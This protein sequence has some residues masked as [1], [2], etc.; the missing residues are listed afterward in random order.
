MLDALTYSL[1]DQFLGE[2][3]I[4]EMIHQYAGKVQKGHSTRCGQ[5]LG[6]IASGLQ[7]L[8]CL[9]ITP[10]LAQ[11]PRQGHGRCE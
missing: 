6:M 5:N 2:V 11:V 4:V 8:G 9:Q 1:Q 10:L 3:E 7:T